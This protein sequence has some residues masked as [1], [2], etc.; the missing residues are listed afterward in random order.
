MSAAQ[1]ANLK[2]IKEKQERYNAINAQQNAEAKAKAAA[3][4]A[5]Q[6]AD[7]DL[8]AEAEFIRQQKETREA[9]AVRDDALSTEERSAEAEEVKDF[10]QTRKAADYAAAKAA[11]AVV[12]ATPPQPRQSGQNLVIFFAAI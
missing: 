6:A 8:E 3:A 11:E 4:E 1:K 10:I 12:K 7:P 2:R 9:E 5:Q